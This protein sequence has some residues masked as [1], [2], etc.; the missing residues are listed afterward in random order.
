MHLGERLKS[1]RKRAGLSL[2]ALGERAGVSAQSI[3]KYE[4]ELVAPGSEAVIR[5]AKAL[6]MSIEWLLRPARAEPL[7]LEPACRSRRSRLA[8]RQRAQIEAQASDWL[9]RR[10]AIEDMLHERW[11]FVPPKIHRRTEEE[12][13]GE[14]VAEAL[15]QAWN[16]GVDAIPDFIAMLEMQGVRVVCVPGP[17]HFDALT[18]LLSSSQPVIVVNRNAPGDRQRLSLAYELGRLILE[19]PQAWD[20]TRVERAAYR[21]ARAFLAPRAVVWHELGTSRTRLNLY[22]LHLLKHRYGMSMQAWIHRARDLEIISRAAAEEWRRLF[23]QAGWHRVEPGVPYPSE[24]TTQLERLALRALVEGRI[25]ESRAAEALGRPL[26][27]FLEEVRSEHNG[28][29]LLALVSRRRA[30]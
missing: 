3:S 16:L 17:D 5:L 23:R 18:L 8:A 11:T 20:E 13:K 12:D 22:E 1:A 21:F 10:L 28:L 6:G 25:G 15:R 9:E 14:E 7:R 4:R 24:K 2:R 26:E 29:P 19:T 30:D 27:T